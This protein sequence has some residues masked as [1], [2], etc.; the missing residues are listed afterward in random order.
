MKNESI[1]DEEVENPD[2]IPGRMLMELGNG[3][4]QWAS[5]PGGKYTPTM[6]TVSKIPPGFYEIGY[7][8]HIGV[9]FEKKR[10]STDELYQLP[11][12]ELTDIIN[13]IETFWKKSEK[14]KEY[15]FLHK[16]GILLYGDPGTGKSGIIQLCT[17]YL[18]DQME[19]I[20]INL[21]NGDQLDW[22][23]QV[24]GSFRSIE[25]DRP[26][27]VIL[28]DID[29][30]AGEGSW[31]TSMLL[32]LLDGVKQIE[33]VVYIA[34]T[35]Y[36]QKLEERITNRPSRFDRRYEV[37]MPSEEVRRS[38]LLHKLNT[39]DLKEINIDEWVRRTDKMS[40]AHL[41][42][43]VISVVAMGN[44]FESTIDRLNGLK[45]TP[46]IKQSKKKIGFS[47]KD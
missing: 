16:R 4:S 6:P 45:K 32:N 29:G 12:L 42:E 28:E 14:Y 1:R 2:L 38:Y 7:D 30:I 3:Y 8:G 47:E 20:V 46:S 27:I 9:Y 22:Y 10:V 35:N 5:H 21:T 44:S 25:P 31:S 24:V 33:N 34:T 18:V 26:I 37:G 13:D 40:L 39:E 41:R 11:S 43:L 36:P 23:S 17:K 15:G 19:G